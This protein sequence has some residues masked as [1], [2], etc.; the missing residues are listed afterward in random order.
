MKKLLLVTTILS[1]GL[2][3][4]G[5]GA[6]TPAYAQSPEQ[7]RAAPLTEQQK[8]E[9]LEKKLA[10]IKTRIEGMLAKTEDPVAKAEA[11]GAYNEAL[12]IQNPLHRG[13]AL[14]K[15]R[16]I[17]AVP[18]A[19]QRQKLLSEYTAAP[20]TTATTTA[21][22]QDLSVLDEET[23]TAATTE[24]KKDLIYQM[25][26]DQYVTA[27]CTPLTTAQKGKIQAIYDFSKTA[28]FT[29][30]E[31]LLADFE[32]KMTNFFKT[33][34]TPNNCQSPE[35]PQQSS[36]GGGGGGM[37]QL[38]Q[39]LKTL[40]PAA[41]MSLASG[42][43][44]GDAKGIGQQQLSALQSNLGSSTTTSQQQEYQQQIAMV[45]Q[46]LGAITQMMAGGGQQQQQSGQNGQQSSG[47][48]Q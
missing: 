31:T 42:G 35:T 3:P 25:L 24:G 19:D 1:M 30:E 41:A 23:A 36:S 46:G 14:A 5:Y 33:D 13:K 20:Q 48:C 27:S 18:K 44:L 6:V 2:N 8:Q 16:K 15:L 12:Q 39:L 32:G 45:T 7:T 17:L 38:I 28:K 11:E 34:Y 21:A 9:L 4:L 47:G 10:A 29:T 26:T 22:E 43:S 37:C 40:I